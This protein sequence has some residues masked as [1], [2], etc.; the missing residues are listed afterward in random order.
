MKFLVLLKYTSADLTSLT[1]TLALTL[2]LTLALALT[3]TL[4]LSKLYEENVI[5][6]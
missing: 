3:P 5:V 2:T 6:C 1:L 4:A